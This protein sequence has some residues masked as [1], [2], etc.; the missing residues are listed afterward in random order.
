MP[1]RLDIEYFPNHGVAG[2]HI[3]RCDKTLKHGFH[4]EQIKFG[5]KGDAKI[6]AD[7]PLDDA[8]FWHLEALLRIIDPDSNSS[9]LSA[10][11]CVIE[12]AFLAGVQHAE[13]A[14]TKVA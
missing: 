6:L 4:S 11:E 8:Q 14:K 9:P 1:Y 7:I 5:E 12:T 2:A 3:E 13:K 10:L